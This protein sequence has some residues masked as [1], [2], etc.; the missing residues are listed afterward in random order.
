MLEGLDASGN[1]LVVTRVEGTDNVC[2]DHADPASKSMTRSFC[3]PTPRKR[4]DG[5]A[6]LDISPKG[7]FAT[8]DPRRSPKSSL[9]LV[10][11]SEGRV[12]RTFTGVDFMTTSAVDD[13][14]RLAW[15][16]G[17]PGTLTRAASAK[18]AP[19]DLGQGEPLGWAPRGRLI[20]RMPPAKPTKKSTTLG[21]RS[22][23][24]VRVVS[25]LPERGEDAGADKR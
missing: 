14:G 6:T 9:S 20:L 7:R 12:L 3:I 22:C 17:P 10:S 8:F 19:T 25:Y 24:L 4:G 15:T 23:D 13:D 16:I 11:M 1:K 5:L 2:V 21:D 18:S